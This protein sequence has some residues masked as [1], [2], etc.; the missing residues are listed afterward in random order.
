MISQLSIYYN[1]IL[2]EQV[3]SLAQWWGFWPDPEAV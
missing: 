1:E 3:T 2:R